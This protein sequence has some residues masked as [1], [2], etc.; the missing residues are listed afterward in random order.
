MEWLFFFLIEVVLHVS[1]SLTFFFVFYLSDFL[2]Y[3][4]I[5]PCALIISPDGIRELRTLF[6]D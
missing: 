2:I 5:S 4:G 3:S 6:L 1:T